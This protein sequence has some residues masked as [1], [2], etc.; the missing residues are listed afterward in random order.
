MGR[1][2]GG[3]LPHADPGHEGP[4]AGHR[5]HAVRRGGPVSRQPASAAIEL[6]AR[7]P[8]QR[9]RTAVVE[10]RYGEVEICRPE[11]NEDR[12]LPRSVRLR[13]VEVREV[14][15]PADVEPLHWRL[16]TTHE[17]A[18]AAGGMADRRLVPAVAG[19][20]SKCTG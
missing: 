20:S 11:P 17:I 7:D 19:S 6:P 2:A 18:D 9:K 1:G 8:G 13:L 4:P 5:R 12:S 10:M 3:R 14:D 15:P 16:L